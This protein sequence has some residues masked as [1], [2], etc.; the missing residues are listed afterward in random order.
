MAY[1]P[2]TANHSASYIYFQVFDIFKY[3]E[4]K[5]YTLRRLR[6][7]SPKKLTGVECSMSGLNKEWEYF[8]M[9]GE[10]VERHILMEAL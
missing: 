2:A 8:E 4:G 5:R 10:D 7:Y 9:S 3:R 6:W 1:S